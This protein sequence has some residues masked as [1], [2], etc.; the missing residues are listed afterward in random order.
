MREGIE[1]LFDE[2]S[3]SENVLLA[4]RGRESVGAEAVITGTGTIAGRPVALMADDGTSR[5]GPRT[6]EAAEKIIRIQE[7]ALTARVPIVYVLDSSPGPG[8]DQ[9]HASPGRRGA[10]RIL[11]M[12]VKLSGVV[13]Q[14]CMLVGPDS[15]AG[16]YIPAFCDLVIVDRAQASMVDDAWGHL[17]A[18]GDEAAVAVAKRY[19]SYFPSHWEW[20]APVARPA[21]P[22]SE[23]SIGQIVPANEDQSFDMFELLDS[24]LDAGSLLELHARWAPELIV[25]LGRLNGRAIG[26]LANQPTVRDGALLADAADKGARFVR[27]CNAFNL[28]LLFLVDVA[29]L[30]DPAGELAHVIRHRARMI[31]AVSEAT[32]PKISVIVRRAYGAG[33]YAMAGPPLEPDACLALPTASTAMGDVPVDALVGPDDLRAELIRR[34]AASAGKRREWP[35]KRNAISPV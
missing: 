15:A 2:G 35:A 14:V 25:G 11:H 22:A 20:A 31:G 27:T 13:P 17:L 10:G 7:Q 12:Q 5:G 24:L 29:R 9:V 30:T 4:G 23:R 28:P 34:F 32:V 21:A 26:V 19:L 8:T 16:A 33:L 18:V 1:S 3:F 6:P